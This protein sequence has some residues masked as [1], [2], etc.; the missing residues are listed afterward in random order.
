MVL[1]FDGFAAVMAIVGVPVI[2]FMAAAP[3][4][5]SGVLYYQKHHRVS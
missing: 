5:Y 3:A 1:V 2:L 4:V